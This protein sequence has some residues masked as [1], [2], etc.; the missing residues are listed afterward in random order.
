MILYLS[1]HRRINVL[2]FIPLLI[3]FLVSA[4]SYSQSN[5]INNSKLIKLSEYV[6]SYG[7]LIKDI[8]KGLESRDLATVVGGFNKYINNNK[9]VIELAIELHQPLDH[10]SS[11]IEEGM[12]IL[13]GDS[14][15][16]DEIISKAE[17][18][19][20][21]L[22]KVSVIE[23]VFGNPL[24]DVS[25]KIL[26]SNDPKKRSFALRQVYSNNNLLKTRY[27]N[28]IRDLKDKRDEVNDWMLLARKDMNRAIE[29]QQLLREIN[30]SPGGSII[31]AFNRKFA[32][33]IL[34][35]EEYLMPVLFSRYN[36]AESLVKK[37][38]HVLKSMNKKI[39]QYKKLNRLSRYY[40]AIDLIKKSALDKRKKFQKNPFENDKIQIDSLKKTLKTSNMYKS[41]YDINTK[42]LQKAVEIMSM[43]NERTKK[44]ALD[45]IRRGASSQSNPLSDF[46]KIASL[47]KTLGNDMNNINSDIGSEVS[48]V[49]NE[50]SLTVNEVDVTI[51][52]L[53]LQESS[54][55][56]INQTLEINQN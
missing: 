9:K 19:I 36:E 47:V 26:Q 43:S 3:L 41:S 31:N 48:T 17:S 13:N 4:K 52:V 15:V 1:L 11:V 27:E 38:D 53:N 30:S 39:Q 8:E 29:S 49:S 12:G 35:S 51:F 34:D 46:L 54:D 25:H 16:F 14:L 7:Y 44:E 28:K 5:N 22:K 50:Y 18:D 2:L 24:N 32:Y 45:I 33:L 6:E 20:S 42:R 21:R 40:Y 56:K 37:Y 23:P 55:H 10:I